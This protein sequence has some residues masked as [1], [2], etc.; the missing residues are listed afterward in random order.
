M[1]SRSDIVELERNDRKGAIAYARELMRQGRW[2]P[3]LARSIAM[4]QDDPGSMI[5]EFDKL[6]RD[7]GVRLDG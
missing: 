2:R 1:A 7:L 4:L 3:D 6:R 5:G